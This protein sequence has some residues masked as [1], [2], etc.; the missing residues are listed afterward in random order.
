MPTPILVGPSCL[1]EFAETCAK[2]LLAGEK[3]RFNFPQGCTLQHWPVTEIKAVNEQFLETLRDRANVYAL[4][5]RSAGRGEDWRAVYVGERKSA[6][7]RG[8]ITEHMI[9]KDH[10]TGSMLEAVKTAVGAQQEIGITFIKVQPES[11]RLF[12][13]ETIIVNH[14]DELP[15]NTHR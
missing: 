15:W 3:H 4:F 7:L 5:V 11:L 1:A 10:R 14:Q 6:G 2:A 8:R 12:V 9:H 13:E